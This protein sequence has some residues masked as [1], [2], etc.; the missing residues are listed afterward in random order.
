M[1]TLFLGPRLVS[2]SRISAAVFVAGT[3]AIGFTGSAG[4]R[5]SEDL[6]GEVALI[7]AGVEVSRESC[8]NTEPELLAADIKQ[9]LAT[10]SRRA[11]ESHDSDESGE[12][13]FQWLLCAAL[14]DPSAAVREEAVQNVGELETSLALPILELA[15]A[16]RA[17]RVR[18]AAIDV[19]T[20][21][22]G[23]Q[24]VWALE[25]ALN[26]PLA[27]VREQAV[28]ALGELSGDAA[29]V[30][31]RRAL[32]DR[33][34]LVRRAAREMLDELSPDESQRSSEERWRP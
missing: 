18:E 33:E 5:S 11:S 13:A 14:L 22:G 9:R 25:P 1:A 10:L 32:V 23:E 21:I 15:L 2:V 20:Q 19:L 31:L 26:D 16:D 27:L 29:I 30:L 8:H 7:V 6:G 24:A 4:A 28:Y 12:G 34:L 17:R 3:L